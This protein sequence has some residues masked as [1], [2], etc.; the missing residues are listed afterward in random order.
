MRISYSISE[1]WLSRV[2][3]WWKNAKDCLCLV[4]PRELFQSGVCKPRG[5]G[6]GNSLYMTWYGCAARIAPFFSASRYTISPF[7]SRKLYMTDPFFLDWYMNGPIFWHPCINAH[8][9]CIWRVPFL[10]LCLN[11]HMFAQIF[12]S[13][14]KIETKL[15]YLCVNFEYR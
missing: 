14:T 4:L 1:C 8:I 13:E 15:Y 2:V 3:N 5:G 7:F 6:G 10:H 12:S 9:F 11:V